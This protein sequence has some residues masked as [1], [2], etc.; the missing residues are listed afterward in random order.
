VF[1]FLCMKKAA[2]IK[3]G[4]SAGNARKGIGSAKVGARTM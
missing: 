1:V 3:K 2:L 4:G